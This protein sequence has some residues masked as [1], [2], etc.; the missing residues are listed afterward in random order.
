MDMNVRKL[1]EI[2][3]LG[4]LQSMGSQR[5]RHDW[6]TEQQ[7]FHTRISKTVIVLTDFSNDWLNEKNLAGN[8]EVFIHLIT[9][10]T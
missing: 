9:V 10:Y 1:W 6:A 8:Q 7:Q 3:K 4:M 5:V 2:I